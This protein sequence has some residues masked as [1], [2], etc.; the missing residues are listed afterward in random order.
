MPILILVVYKIYTVTFM[1]Q[2][3]FIYST[4]LNLT[5][6]IWVLLFSSN[7]EAVLQKNPVRQTGWT[8]CSNHKAIIDTLRTQVQG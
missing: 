1:E 7:Y 5:T 8:I 4:N 2:V 3:S 6:T